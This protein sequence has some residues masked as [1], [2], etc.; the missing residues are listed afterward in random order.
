MI[1]EVKASYTDL[2]K[3]AKASI[4]FTL[5]YIIQRGIQF[6]CMPIFTRIMSQSE[7]GLYSVFFSW[8]NILSI[9]S[10]L[11]MFKGTFNRAMI[12]Y[13]DDREGYTSS[14]QGL[15]I[16]ISIFFCLLLLLIKRYVSM[17]TGFS[18]AFIILMCT[19]IIFYPPLQYWLQVQ[20]FNF[21]YKWMIVV[22]IINSLVSTSLGILLA[23]LS[24]HP[25]EALISSVVIVNVFISILIGKNI[26]KKGKTFYNREYWW[27][28]L[29]MAMPLVPHYL[30]EVV[31]GHSD[32]LMINIM[33]GS[34]EAGIYN[35]VYQISMV[36]TILRI[37]INGAFIPWMYK[38]MHEYKNRKI[39]NVTN[40]LTVATAGMMA[41]FII[42]GPELLKIAA[43]KSYYE[44]VID[45][46]AIMVAN[47]FT[48]VYVLFFSVEVYFE[49][50]YFVAIASAI[51]AVINIG[52]NYILI[53]RFGYLIAGYTTLISY[54]LLAISHFVF[55]RIVL[56]K[57]HFVEKLFDMRVII[58]ATG[59]LV[60]LG[61]SCSILYKTVYLRMVLAIAVVL[62]FYKNRRAFI[63]A[64]SEV[65]NGE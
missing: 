43:P 9:F 40:L 1:K 38:E 45:I 7:Y 11:D 64:F 54:F 30:S 63:S 16:T 21:E 34:A 15:T 41:V 48:Y 52:L 8:F 28:S 47:F 12:R 22:T 50:K 14:V 51:A 27:W 13:T 39:N 60:V 56:K 53:P 65:R 31:L 42:I 33:C 44:A 37:G 17:V 26:W 23:V 19:N 2:S 46:P 35:I 5:C 59:M 24:K 49:K 36:M 57:R 3:P 20:R 32:R 4:W 29:T 62:I 61:I 18:D 55:Y 6:L 58:I 10:S 25:S